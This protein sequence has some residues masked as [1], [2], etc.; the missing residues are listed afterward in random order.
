MEGVIAVNTLFGFV[1]LHA[2]AWVQV[3][4]N[5][6]REQGSGPS[7]TPENF[8]REREKFYAEQNLR[9]LADWRAV[10][11]GPEKGMLLDHRKN[12]LHHRYYSEWESKL[13]PLRHNLL[14]PAGS[15]ELD[16]SGIIPHGPLFFQGC[17]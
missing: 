2:T 8:S 17:I 7:N 9:A 5:G 15:R 4:D 6:R 13:V 11:A 1:R 12:S 10:L 3:Q 14:L 16:C